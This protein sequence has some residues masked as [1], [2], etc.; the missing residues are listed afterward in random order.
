MRESLSFAGV[1]M[2]YFGGNIG[3]QKSFFD[4]TFLGLIYGFL[5]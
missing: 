3:N 1:K 2:Y 5:L 4:D